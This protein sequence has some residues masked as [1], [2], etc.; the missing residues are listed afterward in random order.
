MPPVTPA[1]TRFKLGTVVYSTATLDEIS[2]KDL[3]GLQGELDQLGIKE[4]WSDIETA[5]Q[6]LGKLPEAQA[7]QHPMALLLFAVTVWASR[8]AAGEVIRF[9]DAIDFPMS[10]ITF[11]SDP[12]DH[13]K[14][15]PTKARKGTQAKKTAGKKPVSEAAEGEPADDVAPT[16]TTSEPPSGSD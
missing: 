3:L 10:Q 14:A 15:G 13:K 7:Q 8:R 5:G 4:T 6:E 16:S 2:L 12:G 11:L 1:T 9:T